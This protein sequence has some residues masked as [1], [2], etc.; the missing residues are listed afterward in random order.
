MKQASP[1]VVS[2]VSS[3]V[4]YVVYAEAMCPFR[5]FGRDPNRKGRKLKKKGERERSW[6]NEKKKRDPCM[7]LFGQDSTEQSPHFHQP[8]TPTFPI[9]IG[10]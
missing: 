2:G 7:F 9:P 10:T 8:G 6:K 3:V 5:F 1:R 4:G